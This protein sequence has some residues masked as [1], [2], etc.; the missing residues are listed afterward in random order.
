MA[1]N[2]WKL[3]GSGAWNAGANWESG[4]PTASSDAILNYAFISPYVLAYTVTMPA[5][6]YTINSLLIDSTGGLNAARITLKLE[7][8]T[9][10]HVTTQFQVVST[11]N[12]V[13]SDNAGFFGNT[14]SFTSSGLNWTLANASTV[15]FTGAVSGG[16]TFKFNDATADKLVFGA[17]QTDSF[18]GTINRFQI[19][20]SIELN[21]VTYVAGTYTAVQTGSQLEIRQSGST[22]F[23][24]SSVS[25]AAGS[26][27]S[28]LMFG[29]NDTGGLRLTV[30]F[31]AGTRIAA[32]GSE[33]AV[34]DLRAGDQVVT[35]Q[36]GKQVLSAVRWVGRRRLA[37][38]GHP[39]APAVMPV[40]IRAGA[41]A[42]GVPSRDLLVSPD[43]AILVGTGGNSG[44][45]P[46]R[47]LINQMSICQETGL[48]SVEYF[49][50]E[51]DRH[52]ILLAEG[53]ASESYLETGNRGFFANS[54]E[55]LILH[56]DLIGDEL[57]RSQAGPCLPFLTEDAAVK[58]VWQSLRDRAIAAGMTTDIVGTTDEAELRIVAG[59]R[60]YRPVTVEAG[61]YIFALPGGQEAR[62]VSRSGRITDTQPWLDD[63]RSLGVAVERIA[64]RSADGFEEIAMDHPDLSQGWWEAERTGNRLH[65]WTDG[66]ATIRLTGGPVLL[67]LTLAGT[68]AYLLPQIETGHRKAA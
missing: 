25:Y 34:E 22:V 37:L 52:S 30:C 40:R 59:D 15:Q 43:H 24:F 11:G 55:P 56:P 23:T 63:R 41:F 51:L 29:S 46:A 33:I 31:A 64:L 60:E 61:R 35:L 28:S 3:A 50:V 16:V 26:T 1:A 4:I 58:P 65:R 47:R 2:H 32:D 19:G 18:A 10:L 57:A 17:A 66:D 6:D 7:S 27:V 38:R 42:D 8:G 12:T 53:L 5:A 39:D 36:A 48:T 14:G 44:L 45:V 68:A 21:S 9:T 49:H 67:E 13:A 20:N 54:G 62:L